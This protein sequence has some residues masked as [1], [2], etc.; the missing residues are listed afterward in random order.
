MPLN[1]GPD[2]Y[3]YDNCVKTFDP[4]LSS[5]AQYSP[6]PP[7]VVPTTTTSHHSSVQH[8][9]YNVHI[10]NQNQNQNIGNIIV[11]TTEMPNNCVTYSN[12]IFLPS[13][14]GSNSLDQVVDTIELVKNETETSNNDAHSFK[15]VV[16]SDQRFL[17][18]LVRTNDLDT[19]PSHPLTSSS[20]SFIDQQQSNMIATI[21]GISD[22]NL[23]L[24][25]VNQMEIC[26]TDQS[27]QDSILINSNQ[28]QLA[29]QMSTD[30][31]RNGSEIF[32]DSDGQLYRQIIGNELIPV[33][34]SDIE[35]PQ[36]NQ[37]DS[38]DMEQSTSHTHYQV[39]NNFIET[40]SVANNEQLNQFNIEHDNILSENQITKDQF[41]E[42][43]TPKSNKDQ[44]RMLLESTMSPLRKFNLSSQQKKNAIFK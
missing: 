42:H 20:S 40:H 24:N 2:Q 7:S 6:P 39:A 44:Q 30:F 35:L 5:A 12:I 23:I 31:S 26:S 22:N 36:S 43:S 41:V 32:M 4:N 8:I 34:F 18:S 27:D 3:V 19:N 33:T 16:S 15:Y 9:P 14:N 11:P 25:D 10:Q 29:I 21:S 37:F 1:L 28:R 17:N 38:N 13:T